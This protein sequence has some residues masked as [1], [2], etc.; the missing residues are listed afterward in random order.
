MLQDAEKFVGHFRL[1]PHESLQTLHPFEIGND[2][3]AGV[4]Q[5]I[6]N[7]ENFVPALIENHI[8][9]RRGRPIGAFSQNAAL[10]FGG[11]FFRDHAIDRARRQDIAFLH[12]HFVR[13]DPI[14]LIERAQISFFQNVLL[15]CFHVDSF[16]IVNGSGRIADTHDFDSGLQRER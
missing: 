16:G 3:A 13:I 6:G 2:H 14:A 5:N 12:Q 8:C 4:A 11:I 9:F 1:A 15:R 10:Q 7:N